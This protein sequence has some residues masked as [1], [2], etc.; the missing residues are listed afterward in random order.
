MKTTDKQLKQNKCN[1]VFINAKKKKND[2]NIRSQ[3]TSNT[4]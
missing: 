2:N 3:Y 1:K 4:I